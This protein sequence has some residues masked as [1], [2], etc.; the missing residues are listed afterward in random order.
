MTTLL[1][2]LSG[3]VQPRAGQVLFAGVAAHA[4]PQAARCQAG[5]VRTSQIPQPFEGL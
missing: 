5:L 3:E 1:K 2:M 4:Q